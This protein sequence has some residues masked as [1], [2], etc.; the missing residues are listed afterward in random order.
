MFTV[1][2]IIKMTHQSY[3]TKTRHCYINSAN[4][5]PQTTPRRQCNTGRI[6]GC[7]LHNTEGKCTTQSIHV[8]KKSHKTWA[9]NQKIQHT[10]Y[11]ILQWRHLA[12]QRKTLNRQMYNKTLKLVKLAFKINGLVAYPLAQAYCCRPF[13]CRKNRGRHT[14]M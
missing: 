11:G 10:K 4:W 14:A 13:L 1:L 12:V 8:V 2:F 6:D 3:H 7:Q 9:F 5:K